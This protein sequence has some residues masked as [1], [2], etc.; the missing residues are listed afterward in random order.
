MRNAALQGVQKIEPRI[1]SLNKAPE[2]DHAGFVV[3]AEA[4]F[5][6]SGQSIPALGVPTPGQ[7]SPNTLDFVLK[8]V[9]SHMGQGR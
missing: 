8:T 5:C 4:S 6:W 3:T 1:V 9:P 7:V 2:L